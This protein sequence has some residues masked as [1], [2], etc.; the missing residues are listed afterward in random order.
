[1]LD[2]KFTIVRDWLRNGSTTID[3]VDHEDGVWCLSSAFPTSVLIE[4]YKTADAIPKRRDSILYAIALHLE[5]L[6]ALGKLCD[7]QAIDEREITIRFSRENWDDI[8][9]IDRE[10]GLSADFDF[11][12]V[13]AMTDR[14]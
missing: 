7:G 3:W 14:E 4:L 5:M 8:L 6:F 1:M 9:R 12:V 13:P 10:M 2:S 11:H